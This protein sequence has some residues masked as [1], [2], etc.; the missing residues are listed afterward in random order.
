MNQAFV[1]FGLIV[2]VTLVITYWAARRTR[3]TSE[4]Y[5]AG[6][7]LL[8]PDSNIAHDNKLVLKGPIPYREFLRRD[9]PFNYSRR[10]A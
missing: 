8:G 2:L 10:N 5:A 1:L 6:R 3:T 4:F 9:W 7:S